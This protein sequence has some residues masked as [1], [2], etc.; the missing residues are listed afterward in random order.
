MRYLLTGPCKDD[1]SRI[2]ASPAAFL[3][4]LSVQV[5]WDLPHALGYML[6]E[7]SER[8]PY[9]RQLRQAS[10]KSTEVQEEAPYS[11]HMW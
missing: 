5:S 4:P 6:Q 8:F 7:S 1:C 2:K 9:C 10:H 3:Q 11:L